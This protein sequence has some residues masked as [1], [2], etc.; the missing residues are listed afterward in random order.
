MCQDRFTELVK[1]LKEANSNMLLEFQCFMAGDKTAMLHIRTHKNLDAIDKLVQ[2]MEH[3]F[4]IHCVTV[5]VDEIGYFN[6]KGLIRLSASE[7]Q[8]ININRANGVIRG[9][10]PIIGI[11]TD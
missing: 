1:E 10:N 6:I 4:G 7:Q 11:T 3:N 5:E 2:H 9:F 8:N